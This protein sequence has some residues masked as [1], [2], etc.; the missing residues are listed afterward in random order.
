VS[1]RR[2]ED[3]NRL[4]NAVSSWIVRLPIDE[5]DP[6]RRLEAILHGVA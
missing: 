4:G 6:K 5:P 1:V 3:K 2:D